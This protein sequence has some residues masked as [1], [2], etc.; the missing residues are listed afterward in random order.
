MKEYGDK[1][2]AENGTET[3][4]L[5]DASKVSPDFHVPFQRK[6]KLSRV[7]VVEAYQLPAYICTDSHA[8]SISV[9]NSNFHFV[10]SIIGCR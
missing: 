5:A 2:Q 6:L 8:I 7:I 3:A 9:I 10:G 1:W 4:E